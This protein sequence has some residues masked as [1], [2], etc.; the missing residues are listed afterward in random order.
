MPR[1]SPGGT[2]SRRRCASPVRGRARHSV[3]CRL[4]DGA[5]GFDERIDGAGYPDAVVR[6]RQGGTAV[7]EQLRVL[8]RLRETF[9]ELLEESGEPVRVELVT[10][11]ATHARHRARPVMKMSRLR[12]AGGLSAAASSRKT[13]GVVANYRPR[14]SGLGLP[15][16]RRDPTVHGSEVLREGAKAASNLRDPLGARASS[17]TP[18]ATEA[19]SRRSVDR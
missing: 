2:L 14:Q 7:N 15:F 1:A 17:K 18:A 9:G 11:V 6:E 19:P 13:S 10:G 5:D 16:T 4:P 3:S 12:N 8:A